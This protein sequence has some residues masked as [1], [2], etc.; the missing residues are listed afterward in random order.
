VGRYEII[1]K[2]RSAKW[3]LS[4]SR[5]HRFTHFSFTSKPS[6]LSDPNLDLSEEE[7]LAL[8]AAAIIA[9]IKLQRQVSKKKTPNSRSEK[10]SAA[11]PHG[12]TGIIMTSLILS[13]VIMM[14]HFKTLISAT[15]Y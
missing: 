3:Q 14:S 11:S 10:D 12:N 7:V 4:N 13:H 1:L 15:I 5:G 8:N 6:C 9:N 2:Q